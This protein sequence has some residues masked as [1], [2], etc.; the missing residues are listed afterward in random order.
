MTL[1]NITIFAILLLVVIY[2]YGC[3]Q[4]QERQEQSDIPVW[5][6]YKDDKKVLVVKNEPGP[7]VSTALLPEGQEPIKHPF[8]SATA[9]D[10]LEEDNLHTLLEKAQ[11][12]DE[13]ISLLRQNGYKFEKKGINLTQEEFI[14]T[15]NFT[16]LDSDKNP[17][18]G[19]E[20]ELYAQIPC[21]CPGVPCTCAD[22]FLAKGLT[23]KLGELMIE[24]D[25]SPTYVLVNPG[26]PNLLY[27]TF[28][29]TSRVEYPD[30][31]P[32]YIYLDFEKEVIPATIVLE[33]S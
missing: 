9:L 6:V 18:A 15:I 16:I 17:V 1:K 25:E 13:F 2:I 26:Q 20:L 7:I 10:P 21:E 3:Q 33:S 5:N 24:L 32:D 27:A 29:F 12:F 14:Y 19:A 31:H 8:L 22:K 11:N 23:N 4:K 28:Y 30:L